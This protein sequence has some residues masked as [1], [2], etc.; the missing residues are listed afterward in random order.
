MHHAD[1]V[2]H[3][4]VPLV[5]I[6]DNNYV[7]PTAVAIWSIIRSKQPDTRYAVHIVCAS[8][9]EESEAEFKKLESEQVSVTIIRQDA[10][11]FS[12]LHT[13]VQGTHCVATPAALLKFV[14]PELLPQYDKVLYLDG[15]IIVRDDLTEIYETELGTD[16]V[17]AVVDSGS[18]YRSTQFMQQVAHYFNSGVMLLNLAQMRLENTTETLIR[19]KQEQQDNSL[20]DQNI[21]NLVF[22]GRVHTLPVRNNLLS[23]NLKRA[24]PCW[25]IEQL[26]ERYGTD[27]ADMDALFADGRVV[28][29]SSKD[30]PWKH[31]F[32]THAEEWYKFYRSAPIEHTLPDHLDTYSKAHIT[33]SL[34]SYPARID[35]V[36]EVIACL[37]EQTVPADRIALYLAK[38]QFPQLEGDLPDALVDYAAEGKLELHWVDEDLKP[39]KK[40]YYAMQEFPEDLIIIVDDDEYLDPHTIEQLVVSWLRNPGAI[41]ARRVHLITFDP[42]GNVLP[43]DSWIKEYNKCCA[44][45][46]GQLIA[47]GCCGVLYPPHLLGEDVF[48][49]KGITEAVLFA[50]DLWL[51]AHAALR[52]VPVVAA[53]DQV[54][55]KH[56]GDSQETSL[57]K[58]NGLQGQNDVQFQKLCAYLDGKYGEEN[59]FQRLLYESETGVRLVGQEPVIAYLREVEFDFKK[60]KSRLRRANNERD[61]TKKKLRKTQKELKKVKNS[62]AYKLG[63]LITAPFRALKALLRGRGK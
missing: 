18:L 21:F 61:K 62:R 4:P 22:D 49:L 34:T 25:T 10:D 57:Y 47:T 42:D 13:Y 2:G 46:S 12:D 40:Y 50:D 39:H 5:F 59:L 31:P 55:M 23:V 3:Q 45:P 43:Y 54:A 24:V 35:C 37:L 6:S 33:V 44:Q 41:S 27:Y 36:P 19:T 28:H 11:R 15:D 16:L 52:G 17:A 1:S 56:I 9:S 60:T 38:E 63:R 51:K 48:D 30:K 14:L 8:L 53:T 29:F 7:V 26:N 58:T 20:M 32:V